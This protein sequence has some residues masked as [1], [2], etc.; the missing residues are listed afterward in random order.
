MD[1]TNRFVAPVTLCLAFML[2]FAPLIHGGNHPLARLAMELS[3]VAVMLLALLSGVPRQTAKGYLL[4]VAV[5]FWVALLFLLKI[6]QPAWLALP[7]RDF[8]ADT[9]QLMNTYSWRRLSVVGW[10]TYSAL[11]SLLPPLVVFAAVIW[12]PVEA[13]KR[14]VYLLLGMAVFQSVLSLLQYGGGFGGLLLIPNPYNIAT[15]GGT[16]LNKDHLAGLLEMVLP[17]VLGLTAANV[18]IHAASRRGT[19]LQRGM[20]FVSSLQGHRALGFG[21]IAVLL[22]LALIFIRSRA[23]IGLAM[24]GILVSAM[25]FAG[26]LGGRNVYGA[27]GTIVAVIL[28]LAALVGM[29]PVLDRFSEDPLGGL[30]LTIYTSMFDGIRDFF[31][32]GSGPGTFAAVYPAYQPAHVDAFINHAHNDYLE[33]VFDTGL[34]GL[35]LILAG[36]AIYLRHWKQVWRRGT[37]RSFRFIQA[38]AGIGVGLLLLHSLVDF[39]LH[40]PA[41]A[42]YFAFLLALFFHDNTEEQALERQKK[43]RHKTPRLSP[44]AL[45]VVVKK[46][47]NRVSLDDWE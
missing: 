41:N 9:L 10:E 15:N 27:Y 16:Y 6:P 4:F 11:W 21:L 8:H 3:A 39:N 35:L 20:R 12:L 17:L 14:L 37:W 5:L 33:W 31:P 44:E 24:L 36:L 42:L 46:P 26:R 13:V 40:K 47:R 1:A 32:L 7:G 18:G 43:K 34:A 2:L 38:G 19:A 25:V 22:L 28:A 30:R 23:G 45:P 29:A